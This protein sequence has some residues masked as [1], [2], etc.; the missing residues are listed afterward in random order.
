MKFVTVIIFTVAAG[1]LVLKEKAA[2][3]ITVVKA[4]EIKWV[5]AKNH[6][7]G[8]KSCLLHGDP[9][10]GSFVLLLK[11]PAGTRYPPHRHSADEVVSVISG[12]FMVGSGEKLDESKGTAVDT[13]GY[14]SFKA[15][16]PHW[17]IAKADSVL[18]RYGNG[19][20]DIKF[21]NA[22]DDPSKKK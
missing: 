16:S 3:E 1:V 12:S 7:E 17:G 8:V 14:F 19:P 4:A 6:P 21:V 18:L 11:I 20:G 22:A 9:A 10:K 2:D 15:Q 13:G 5:D